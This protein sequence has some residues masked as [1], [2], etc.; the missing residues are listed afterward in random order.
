M[1][2]AGGWG[3]RRWEGMV[4][5]SPCSPSQE[6]VGRVASVAGGGGWARRLDCQWRGEGGSGGGESSDGGGGSGD[7]QWR[8]EGRP[9]RGDVEV[10]RAPVA[11]AAC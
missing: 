7:G 11:A 8:G 1:G 10:A 3:H 9:G 4:K 2:I 5:A 6:G